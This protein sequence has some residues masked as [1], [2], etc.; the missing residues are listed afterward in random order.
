MTDHEICGLRLIAH[1][2]LGSFGALGEGVRVQLARDGRRIL[3][4]AHEKG[5]KN[6]TAVDVSDPRKP[7][8][9][10]QTEL[11]HA[12]MR[13]NSLG[14]AGGLMAVAYQTNRVGLAPAGFEIYDITTPEAPRLVSFFDTA[15]PASRGVHNLWFCDGEYVHM[16]SGA[17]DF[18]PRNPLDDQC[19]RIIDVRTPSKPR[20]VGRWWLPGTRDGDEAPPPVR[21]KPPFDMGFR[22]HNTNVYP[23]R[24][25]RCYL[26]MLDAGAMI[27]DIADKSRPR[28][29]AR[30][31]NSPPF[32]GFTHTLMP[33]FSR[34]IMIVT[35]ETVMPAAE[36]HPKLVWV[37]DGRDETNLVPIATFPQPDFDRY[38]HRGGRYGA[39]NL[40]ENHPDLGAFRSDTIVFGTFFNAGLRVYT[41]SNQYRPEEIAYFVPADSDL[42]YM[43]TTQLN[44]VFVD[45]RGIVYTVD[46]CGAGLYILETEFL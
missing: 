15:G 26:G 9:V 20:E 2:T 41:T 46:R 33:I 37:V 40:H 38:A 4:L 29:V 30:W 10:V 14:I 12:D 16:A 23:E 19:Y 18:M 13:T 17:A 8:V 34:G 42:S 5:P 1:E 27:L 32:S 24:P 7:R 3:W 36:D 44:D 31:D 11:P 6:F 35:D 45:D 22:A 43:K 21:H 39:H 25:D 28:V